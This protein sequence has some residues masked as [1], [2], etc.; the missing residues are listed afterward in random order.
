MSDSLRES[1]EQEINQHDLYRNAWIPIQSL[2]ALISDN[3]S[4]GVQI[5]GKL[6]D[7]R[8]HHVIYRPD[9]STS[10]TFHNLVVYHPT[11]HCLGVVPGL[12]STTHI[13]DS[14]VYIVSSLQQPQ[15]RGESQ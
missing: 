3:R 9:P 1:L 11:R 15:L 7:L 2:D 13:L 5:P 4:D 12:N 6:V 8:G 10:P 14:S